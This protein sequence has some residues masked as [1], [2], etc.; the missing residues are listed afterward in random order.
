MDFTRLRALGSLFSM[1]NQMI[2]NILNY[3]QFHP[4]FPL[5]VC[6]IHTVCAPKNL[7]CMV[8]FTLDCLR[9]MEIKQI[10]NGPHRN[11]EQ[12]SHGP[13]CLTYLHTTHVTILCAY[14][15]GTY[16]LQISTSASR[17]PVC[18]REVE[19]DPVLK[20]WPVEQYRSWFQN[21]L[22]ARLVMSPVCFTRIRKSLT[23]LLL[24]SY[25]FFL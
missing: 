18:N 6:I 2:R 4:D 8:R 1:L 10:L 11:A 16:L 20:P 3:N 12:A 5:Q 7:P 24:H 14:N 23:Q 21:V 15:A 17:L 22:P 9:K 13:F 19:C 25:S